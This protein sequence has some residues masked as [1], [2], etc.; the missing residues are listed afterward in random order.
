MNEIMCHPGEPTG[1]EAYAGWHYRWEEEAAA[2]TS[3][4]A[5]QIVEERG[6]RLANFATAWEAA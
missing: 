1:S 5:R 3:A 6:I 2:L 4:R